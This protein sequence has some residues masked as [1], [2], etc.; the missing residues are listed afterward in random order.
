MANYCSNA[1]LFIGDDSAVT[2]VRDLFA[3]IQR[4]QA[5]SNRY[6]LPDF[7]S[8]GRGYM[9]DIETGQDW[10][11]YETRWVPNL[12]VLVQI[13]TRYELEFI[14]KYDE[15]MNGLYGEAVFTAGD[16]HFAN[17]DAHDRESGQDHQ[18]LQ[19]VRE[20]QAALLAQHGL[21]R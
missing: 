11:L 21:Q 15:P 16:L 10:L 3:E 14:A 6:H 12:E 4:K 18:G 2:G 13:A 8:G 19:K 20:M 9:E 7:V 5:K 17:L 1:V